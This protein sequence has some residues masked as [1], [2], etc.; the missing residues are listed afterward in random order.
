MTITEKDKILY[1]FAGVLNADGRE[2]PTSSTNEHPYLN[3]DNVMRKVTTGLF[4]SLT[5]TIRSDGTILLGLKLSDSVLVG[6]DAFEWQGIS[7]QSPWVAEEALEG[8]VCLAS[9]KRI[10]MP[11]G[12]SG[13]TV[14]VRAKII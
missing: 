3:G 9:G 6:M 14:T 11:F 7:G 13:R 12:K 4:M 5:P 10:S 8:S 1:D 2:H